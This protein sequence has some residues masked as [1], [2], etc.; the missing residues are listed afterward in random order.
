MSYFHPLEVVCRGSETQFQV[1][2]NLKITHLS[3]PYILV[4]RL[5]YQDNH[6]L[7]Y[8]TW[9]HPYIGRNHSETVCYY[10]LK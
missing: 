6:P 2:E 5:I 8:T 10:K 1:G 3:H 7:R 4:A 9:R